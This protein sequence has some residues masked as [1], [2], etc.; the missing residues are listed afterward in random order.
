MARAPRNSAGERIILTPS[1]K[2]GNHQSDDE[3][4]VSVE[5]KD[6]ARFAGK[7]IK[8][9]FLIIIGFIA[10][11]AALYFLLSATLM[12]AIPLPANN[13]DAEDSQE[14]EWVWISRNVFIGGVPDNGE[15]AFVSLSAPVSETYIDKLMQ[16]FRSVPDA[17][18]V[19]IVGGPFGEVTISQ[20]RETIIDGDPTGYTTAITD[21]L[22]LNRQY[23]VLCV[24]G[25]CS[26]GDTYIIHQ[27]NIAGG[28]NGIITTQGLQEYTPINP[29]KQTG[30]NEGEG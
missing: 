21:P 26:R 23:I 7:S 5:A 16:T 6:V 29:E 18:I 30:T 22:E 10:V 2:K 3:V 1:E 12:T 28:V 4:L 20:E 27:D 24:A 19:E 14:K 11:I 25:E 8:T 15:H 17:A 13:G 9:L